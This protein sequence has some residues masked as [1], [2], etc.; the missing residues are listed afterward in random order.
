[1]VTQQKRSWNDLF[2][3]PLLKFFFKNKAFL[4]AL[5]LVVLGL[6]IYAL[7]LGFMKPTVEENSYTT[8][9]FWSL[10]WPFFVV[11]S[12]S[13][14]GRLFCGICPHGFVGKYLTRFGFQK[15][16][17]KWLKNP[18]IGVFLLFFGWWGV[19]YIYPTL[20]K[21]PLSSALFFT[22]MSLVAFGFFIAFKEMAYCKYICPVGTMMRVFSKVS[23]T[24]LGTYHGSCQNCDTF[25]CAKA[26]PYALK[27]FSFDKKA[28][29]GD[30][31][32][33]MECAQVCESVS[34]KV[35]KPSSSLFKKFQFSSAEI[36]AVL[37]ITS[38]I[39]ITM[40]FHHALS[41]VAISDSYFWVQI[42]KW[43]EQ[44][45]GIHG[46]DYVGVSALMCAVIFTF[47]L[48]IGGMYL[49]SKLL[50]AEFKATFFTLSYAF[51]PLFIIGG[52]SHTYEFFFTHHYSTILNGF[53]NGFNL[54]IATIEPL[55]T[56]KD[57]W[58]KIFRVMNYIAVIWALVI[59]AKRLSFFNASFA[60]KIGAFIVASLLIQFYLGLN[61]YR[62]YAFATYGAKKG[63]HNHGAS[64][65]ELFQSVPKDKA[66][67]MQESTSGVVCGM[68]LNRY[69]KTNHYAT[70]EGNVR[71]YCS[72]HCLAE[73]LLI[74]KLPLKEIHV[75][76]VTSLQ[77]ID[78]SKANYVV[79]SRVKGT[80]S[81]KSKYAFA[82]IE[83]A[84]A[85]ASKYGGVVKP[86]NEAL[87]SAEEDFK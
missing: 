76:D 74:K 78:A 63:G 79:G 45:I 82:S 73:D 25:E 59:L 68:N 60:K 72:L 47:S 13:T 37:L 16:M 4:L 17:P 34:F 83:D 3:A 51:I 54:D 69:F 81:E 33:C 15:E 18:M 84:K 35:T 19:Y 55:A 1:M 41:R 70:L 28:S 9:L 67:L 77:F 10:F 31:T 46:V 65:K 50:H 32:L 36:W 43:L 48:A 29:M 22:V 14:F 75:V 62:G 85:F 61:L 27:P 8:A 26:C 49:A 12:L 53:I 40:G 87:Q 66:I 23:F 2:K 56:K 24:W 44:S 30:C 39:T 38:A 7:V 21:T 80:M 20:Y 11:V 52:L 57:A 42:G 58:L 64:A 71:Q 86:F 5:R 6:F